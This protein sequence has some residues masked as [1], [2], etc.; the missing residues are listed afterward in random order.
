MS[1]VNQG[2]IFPV[3][4]LFYVKWKNQDNK[5][6][7]PV[8]VYNIRDDKSGYPHFLVFN[9]GRWDYVSAKRFVPA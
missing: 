2:Q 7:A 3:N 6:S 9:D 4:K 5:F 1:T 8:A